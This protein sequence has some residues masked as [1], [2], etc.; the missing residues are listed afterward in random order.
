LFTINSQSSL[1]HL[2]L[3]KKAYLHF[4][5][6]TFNHLTAWTIPDQSSITSLK[7]YCK[8]VRHWDFSLRDFGIVDANQVSKRAD[9]RSID[10]H[11]LYSNYSRIT[12]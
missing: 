1:S 7:C 8:I 11:C 4:A 5:N 2:S 10:D 3:S 9:R 12:L 6:P